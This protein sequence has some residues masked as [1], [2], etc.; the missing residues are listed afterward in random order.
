MTF[1]HN[2]KG[3]YIDQQKLQELHIQNDKKQYVHAL[4]KNPA[5]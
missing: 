2:M 3:I 4:E 5:F 1:R